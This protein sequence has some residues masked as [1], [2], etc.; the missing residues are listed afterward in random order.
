MNKDEI[1]KN[2]CQQ[3]EKLKMEVDYWKKQYHRLS[4]TYQQLLT[5]QQPHS[6]PLPSHPEP[7]TMPVPA[8][9]DTFLLDFDAPIMTTSPSPEK[10]PSPKL[11]K[12]HLPSPEKV[13]K[14]PE[15]QTEPVKTESAFDFFS[16]EVH[17]APQ[18]DKSICELIEGCFVIEKNSSIDHFDPVRF[19]YPSNKYTRLRSMFDIIYRYVFVNDSP[20]QI[21]D[22]EFDSRKNQ[23][24]FG[25]PCEDFQF[26]FDNLSEKEGE[27]GRLNQF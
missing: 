10:I 1:I 18:L 5:S 7:R 15:I 12:K 14:P 27:K 23:I 8:H 19:L 17:N 26:I 2:L 20:V 6:L 9:E 13:V 25:T 3:N 16:K 21:Y 24:T 11:D 22:D 4:A